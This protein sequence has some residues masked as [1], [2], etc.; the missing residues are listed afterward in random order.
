MVRKRTGFLI[1]ERV[2]GEKMK[3][4]YPRDVY[5]LNN[6]FMETYAYISARKGRK[7]GLNVSLFIYIYMYTVYP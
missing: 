2:L 7:T 5:K 6:L 3:F 4:P 1:G